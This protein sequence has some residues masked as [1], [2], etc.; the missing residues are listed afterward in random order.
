[1]LKD[2]FQ[3][4]VGLSQKAQD[5][6]TIP[7][8][9]GETLAIV[10]A[11]GVLDKHRS[12]KRI[13]T[14]R[15]KTTDIESFV[16]A[17]GTF[18]SIAESSSGRFAHVEGATG[19]TVFVEG[20][21]SAM[22]VLDNRTRSDTVKLLLEKT[23]QFESLTVLD[24]AFNQRDLLKF[25]RVDLHQAGVET[26]VANFRDLQW[27]RADGSMGKLNHADESMGRTVEN[28]VQS[29]TDIPEEISVNVP[30]FTAP[31]MADI[32]VTLTM[33]VQV[34]FQNQSIRLTVPPNE[35]QKAIQFVR[36]SVF[37]RILK[38]FK[39]DDKIQVVMGFKGSAVSPR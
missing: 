39:D 32:S 16:S 3:S 11:D 34:D 29:S 35:A 26:F 27:N 19:A 30:V 7:L 24:N 10:G 12:L 37:E 13:E 25:L 21:N 8:D 9:N 5:V 31:S 36:Q 17:V 28:R 4:I 18:H 14:L 1:M 23:H 20:E 15:V 22:C 6:Q 2:L 38:A 33:V